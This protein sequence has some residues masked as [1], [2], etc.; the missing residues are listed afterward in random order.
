MNLLSTK[1][2]KNILLINQISI[3]DEDALKIVTFNNDKENKNYIKLNI[4]LSNDSTAN[5]ETLNKE[6]HATETAEAKEVHNQKTNFLGKKRA[7]ENKEEEESDEI[8]I[9]NE[10]SLLAKNY[11]NYSITLDL[12]TKYRFYK[13]YCHENN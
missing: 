8:E 1:S 12:F 5:D 7:E 3:K 11:S 4:I 13:K 2:F 10:I 9:P 6:H